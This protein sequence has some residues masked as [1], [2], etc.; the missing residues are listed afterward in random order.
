ML[1]IV[2]LPAVLS[3]LLI[4]AHQARSAFDAVLADETRAAAR[5]VATER[6]ELLLSD[7]RLSRLAIESERRGTLGGVRVAIVTND[8]VPIQSTDR[9]ALAEARVHAT[10]P[11]GPIEWVGEDGRRRR[12]M[13]ASV[14][15]TSWLLWFSSSLERETARTRPVRVAVVA[16][17]IVAVAG[18]A[19]GGWLIAG[20]V[21]RPLTEL[22]AIVRGVT[23]SS[24]RR[25]VRMD[26]SSEEAM[27][28]RRE[29]DRT[30]YR[31]E[32][33]FRAQE[34]FAS[35]VAH[36]LKTPIA[37]LLTEAQVLRVDRGTSEDPRDEFVASV[38]E[39]MRR[40][41]RLVDGLLLLT[42]V[43]DNDGVIRGRR[44]DPNEL[45]MDVVERSTDA[46]IAAGVSFRTKLLA[47]AEI[48][49]LVGDPDLLATMLE[50]LVRNALRFAPKETSIVVSVE[51]DGEFCA[52]TVVDEGPGIAAEL[53]T[54]I[55]DRFVQAPEEAA[56]GRGHGLGL[57][58]AQGIAELHG[59][60]ITIETAGEAAGAAPGEG[61]G[62]GCRIR[63]R[64]PWRGPEAKRTMSSV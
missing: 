44:T 11:S 34:R 40:L 48:P 15:N 24:I 28:L 19:F 32:A 38:E 62:T 46:A 23:P 21:L 6:E 60:R 52:I 61:A 2:Q 1:A 31:L 51:H 10:G 39:E 56:R 47:E 54:R 3:V 59:G 26:D 22:T 42:R 57:P 18:A 43:Q 53:Q 41:G 37:T 13:I 9:L 16:S 5:A 29:L 33:A 45:V 58:I 63:V 7:L 25:E 30:L 27:Q 8:G 49:S 4:H 20:I 64:L 55:F 35:N 12:G 50:N 36:E 17:A 14:P